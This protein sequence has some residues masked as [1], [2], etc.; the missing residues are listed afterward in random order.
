[1]YSG[2]PNPAWILSESGSEELRERLR[3]LPRADELPRPD[4]VLGYR[5]VHLTA[6]EPGPGAP[7]EM[8]VAS[9][10]VWIEQADGTTFVFRDSEGIEAWLLECAEEEGYRVPR[11]ASSP[12]SHHE[13]PVIIESHP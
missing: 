7:V 8:Y 2:R 5:G 10:H 4:A 13:Q 1:M 9:G 6:V 3:R 11:S 12:R